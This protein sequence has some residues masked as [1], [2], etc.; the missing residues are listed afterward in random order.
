MRFAVNVFFLFSLFVVFV[1]GCSD[2]VGP[3]VKGQVLLD[4]KPVAGARVMFFGK[5]GGGSVTD[6][7]GKFYLDG[8]TFKTV[9]PGKYI[10][11]VSKYVDM[12]TGKAFEGE[13]YEQAVAAGKAKSE[14]PER[15][16]RNEE[17]PL[18]GIEIK[19]GMNELKPFE[20]K[21]K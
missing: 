17:N 1:T 2:V 9:Q 19:D 7:D 14:L 16:G 5:G 21:S 8:T 10:V 3:K 18:T 13:D 11:M 4:G 6:S 15:Y 12:K 20:L